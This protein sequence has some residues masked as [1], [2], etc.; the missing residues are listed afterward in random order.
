M[1][2]KVKLFELL[3]KENL[4]GEEEKAIQKI[5]GED[6]EAKELYLAHQKIKEALNSRE[7]HISYDELADYLLVKNENEPEDKNIYAKI[8]FIEKHIRECSK[9]TKEFQ[10]FNEEYTE[11]DN[12][13]KSEIPA[14]EEKLPE[15]Q[16]EDKI[17]YKR[18]VFSKYIFVSLLL[19]AFAYG[20][21]YMFSRIVTP[22]NY[23]IATL[24]NNNKFY[25]TR[26]RETEYFQKSL[27][28]LD[29]KNYTQ[30][31][32]YLKDDIKANPKDETIFYSYYILGLTYLET[33]PKSFIGLFPSF[34]QT[35]I[36][37][38]ISNLEKSLQLNNSGKYENINLDSYFYLG[39]ASL[40][41]NNIG[42]A[43]KYFNIVVNEHGSKMNEA[44]TI[45]ND[46][47]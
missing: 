24:K 38:G 25:I 10:I 45:L 42:S 8:P 1:E 6:S 21:M 27:N 22:S 39:K 4:S 17:I 3:Q 29:D 12:V 28:A 16:A 30:T 32:E 14:F 2:N 40:M 37:E 41:K 34:N 15:K 31:I 18:P 26:G 36:G 46:L 47:E 20:G 44:K 19:V 35:N 23:S 13:V 7:N 9:C 33:A 43:K 11:I 5:I